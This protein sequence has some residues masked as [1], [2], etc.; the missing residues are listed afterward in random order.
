MERH[1]HNKDVIKVHKL[2]LNIYRLFRKDSVLATSNLKKAQSVL[3]YTQ[4][5]HVLFVLNMDY[6]STAN[7]SIQYVKGSVFPLQARY[8]PEGG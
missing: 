2:R 5:I 3:E 4:L 6:E 1:R 8:G 7:S